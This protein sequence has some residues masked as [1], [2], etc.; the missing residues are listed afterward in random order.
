[1]YIS[2]LLGNQKFVP[3]TRWD[4]ASKQLEAWTVFCVILLGDAS[5]HPATQEME[6]LVDETEGV[7]ARIHMQAY[8]QPSFP[9][10]ILSL[11]QP[12]FNESF[13]RRLRG[14]TRSS[15]PAST[16]SGYSSLQAT[17]DLRAYMFRGQP[18]PP[19]RPHPIT[20]RTTAPPNQVP[21]LTYLPRTSVRVQNTVEVNPCSAPDLQVQPV[22]LL[23]TTINAAAACGE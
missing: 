21:P 8:H 13:H 9:Y 17:S 1:M 2:Y 4:A 22:L 12:D 20:P 10:S 5:N 15:G 14:S 11:V 3:V 19:P 16:T 7:S 18:P 23:S 6:D